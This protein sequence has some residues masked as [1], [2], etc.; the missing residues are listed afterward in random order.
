[1]VVFVAVMAFAAI[2]GRRTA[3][4]HAARTAAKFANPADFLTTHALA[5]ELERRRNADPALFAAAI[6]DD[7]AMAPSLLEAVKEEKKKAAADAAANAVSFPS[8]GG[9]LEGY[10]YGM[11]YP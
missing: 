1:M 8:G 5:A 7:E 3:R 9:P 10:L 2:K 11:R 4:E 6:A